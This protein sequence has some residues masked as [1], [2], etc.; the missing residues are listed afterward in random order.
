[1][2][3]TK[4]NLNKENCSPISSNCVIWQGPD[5]SCI[6]LCNGDS[7]SEVTYKIAEELCA[8]KESFGFT[9]VDLTCL[10]T[11]CSTSPEPQ[12]TITNILNLII[13]KVCCLSDIVNNIDITV[14]AEIEIRLASCFNI[15]N[16][17]GVPLTSLPQS[18]YVYQIGVFL[19]GLNDTVNSQANDIDL[20]QQQVAALMGTPA[21]TIPQVTPKCVIT[22][23]VP[24]DIDVVVDALESQYCDLASVLGSVSNLNIA[25][26]K[27]CTDLNTQNLLSSGKAITSL[28]TGP[29]GNWVT[30][31]STVADTL[32]NM[33]AMICDIRGAVKTIQS[34]C[35]KVTCDDIIVDFD[36]KR[37]VNDAGDLVLLLFFHPKTTL[38]DTWYDCNQNP[39]TG[40]LYPWVGNAFTITDEAGHMYQGFLQLRNTAL[41]NGILEDQTYYNQGYEVNIANTSLDELSSYT[42]ESNLCLTDGSTSCVKCLNKHIPYVS[43]DKCCTITAIAPVTITYK[44]CQ[45]TTTTTI[46]ISA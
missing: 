31:P 12:K 7:I 32:V 19:C 16:P 14:P 46:P 24:T 4:S 36:I 41:D 37:A 22:P 42:F 18:E 1:M 43:V 15:T 13:N 38:P 17:Q 44:I 8:V 10:L 11:I 6:N 3:P 33:W 34:T 35:C 27:Q 9:D 39:T 30:T 20:L 45:T 23:A 25:L 5:I 21:P 29:G 40:G 2:T 26:G 28:G